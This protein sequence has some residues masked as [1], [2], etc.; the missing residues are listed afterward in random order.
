VG[1][2][3]PPS[4]VPEGVEEEASPAKAFKDD[5]APVSVSRGTDDSFA[6]E[7]TRLKSDLQ[8]VRCCA[9][10]CEHQLIKALLALGH[11]RCVLCTLCGVVSVDLPRQRSQ[12]ACEVVWPA[13]GA[14]WLLEPRRKC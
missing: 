12:V 4:P 5:S 7:R 2:P 13:G 11:A 8:K 14:C 3:K 6:Q 9:V 10:F 1:P